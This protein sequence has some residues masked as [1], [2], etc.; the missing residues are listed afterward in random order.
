MFVV[1]KI[2][3]IYRTKR[4]DI[5]AL[6]NISLT[7]K[8]GEFLVVR[9]PSGSGKT[10]LLLCL[11]GMLHPS[12]G[13]ILLAGNNIYA[14][15]TGERTSFRAQNIGFVFQMFHLVPYLNISDNVLLAA[16][17]MS[18]QSGKKKV[19]ELLSSFNISEREDHKPSELSAGEK[20][21][22][23]VARALYNNPK[24]VLADEPTGNL[25]PQNA[26]E[27]IGYLSGYHKKGGTVIIVTHGKIA[28]QY[29]DRVIY[30]EEGKVRMD[31]GPWTMDDE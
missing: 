15:N 20:Q 12:R 11:G 14:M 7:I 13:R 10:T 21:R 17:K 2:S 16:N 3:K 22:T 5:H 25:D 30:L 9:G 26:G 28:D 6:D 24:I 27:I 19:T 23:A 1:D 31:H 29:A 8:E 4:G 18:K